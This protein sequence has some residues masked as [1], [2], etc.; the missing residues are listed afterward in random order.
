MICVS[1]SIESKNDRELHF[2]KL[3]SLLFT[4]GEKYASL[5]ALNSILYSIFTKE[6]N[7]GKTADEANTT[8]LD[9]RKKWKFIGICMTQ[10]VPNN[11]RGYTEEKYRLIKICVKGHV[12]MQNFFKQNIEEGDSIYLVTKK[13]QMYKSTA[14]Y[15]GD[16]ERVDEGWEDFQPIEN[17]Y[18][19]C[20]AFAKSVNFKF[21]YGNISTP[22]EEIALCVQVNE[23]PNSK[24]GIFKRENTMF[25]YEH[26]TDMREESTIFVE[27]F[28]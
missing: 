7:N 1:H 26:V 21:H 12:L 22:Y 19:V 8:V 4:N 3:Y 9:E 11:K 25:H 24:R 14:F 10:P 20:L 16:N 13:V 18:Q 5:A 17:V 27:L 6:F 15:V 2:H 28:L 23:I